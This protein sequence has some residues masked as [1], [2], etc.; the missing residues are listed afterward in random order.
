M[1][2]KKS[3]YHSNIPILKNLAAKI[4]RLAVNETWIS[5]DSLEYMYRDSIS[6][7]ADFFVETDII[8]HSPTTPNTSVLI[9]FIVDGLAG[10]GEEMLTLE[11]VPPAPSALLSFPFGEGVFFNNFMTITITDSDS[12]YDTITLYIAWLLL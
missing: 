7:A 4:S 11:L 9:T 2:A 1:F 5:R 10:E 3:N 12:T 6:G 8:Y